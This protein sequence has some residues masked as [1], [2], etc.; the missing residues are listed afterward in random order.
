MAKIFIPAFERF[1]VKLGFEP[2]AFKPTEENLNRAEK[3]IE[4]GFDPMQS[5]EIMTYDDKAY[6]M[7]VDFKQENPNLNLDYAINSRFNSAQVQ[8]ML[9]AIHYNH[10]VE[11]GDLKDR[12]KSMILLSSMSNPNRSANQMYMISSSAN[13][14][15]DTDRVIARGDTDELMANELEWLRERKLEVFTQIRKNGLSLNDFTP[16]DFAKCCLAQNENK[17]DLTQSLEQIKDQIA[18]YNLLDDTHCG[19]MNVFGIEACRNKMAVHQYVRESNYDFTLDNAQFQYLYEQREADPVSFATK[20]VWKHLVDESELTLK[21]DAMLMREEVDNDLRVAGIIPQGLDE[22]KLNELYEVHHAEMTMP[23][24]SIEPSHTYKE[25]LGRVISLIHQ[26]NNPQSTITEINKLKE[27]SLTVQ[28]KF[29]LTDGDIQKN[30]NTNQDVLNYF[31][32]YDKENN[33]PKWQQAGLVET[34]TQFHYLDF[35][36]P[37]RLASV[38]NREFKTEIKVESIEKFTSNEV[39]NIDSKV[40]ID[41]EL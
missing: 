39:D 35:E 29:K 4:V 5:L 32:Q 26:N 34:T 38:L 25:T 1:I 33:I 6:K 21:N 12:G 16:E 41:L 37:T 9:Q 36:N 27:D 17:L 3:L 31:N 20:V 13:E 2:N 11:F 14:N 8:E 22:R 19:Q 40:T 24:A 30:I 23:T 15:L 28:S 7:M 10:E 18:D